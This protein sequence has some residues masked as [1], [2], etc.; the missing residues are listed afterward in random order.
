MKNFD[1]AKEFSKKD[2]VN[3]R[4]RRYKNS[5]PDIVIPGYNQ[6]HFQALRADHV[7]QLCNGEI[8]LE[9]LS[10]ELGCVNTDF[11]DFHIESHIVS[12][13]RGDDYDP[14]GVDREFYFLIATEK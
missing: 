11:A 10:Q 3:F 9:R 2:S 6:E 4:S 5:K 13:D 14:Y 12:D 8:D 7:V 1:L